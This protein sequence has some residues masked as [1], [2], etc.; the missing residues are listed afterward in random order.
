[1]KYL[2]YLIKLLLRNR[3]KK[4]KSLLPEIKSQQKLLILKS[5]TL[6]MTES[7]SVLASRNSYLIFKYK[8]FINKWDISK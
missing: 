7:I 1:M 6:G 2:L 5:R 4:Y 8:R 3:V